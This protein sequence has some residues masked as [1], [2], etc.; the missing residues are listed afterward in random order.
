MSYGSRFPPVREELVALCAEL[1]LTGASVVWWT[2][3]LWVHHNVLYADPAA[4][5]LI[6]AVTL[7]LLL[8]WAL[9]LRTGGLR[10]AILTSVAVRGVLVLTLSLWFLQDL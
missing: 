5:T 1:L 4:V 9:W 8:T 6:L 3:L 10:G 2:Y 7:S